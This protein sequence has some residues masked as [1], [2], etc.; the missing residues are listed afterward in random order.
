[1]VTDQNTTQLSW[2][3]QSDNEEKFVIYR[4]PS[5]TNYYYPIADVAE[6]IIDFLDDTTI[7]S[8][9]FS[10]VVQ[11][12]SAP[13]SSILSNEASVVNVNN[14]NPVIHDEF[15][16]FPNPFDQKIYLKKR[17]QKSI[18][19][20]IINSVGNTLV[21]R[22]IE[23][24]APIEIIEIEGSSGIYYVKISIDEHTYTQ[25]IIKR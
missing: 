24:N 12:V 9:G 3:D 10:Y 25:K 14:N 13:D 4:K 11:A 1:M 15:E 20:E 17:T 19:Y 22:F 21:K 7:P 5:A 2:V 18:Q 16:I 6:N 23:H 8:G